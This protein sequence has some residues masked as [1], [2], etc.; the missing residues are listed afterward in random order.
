MGEQEEA[1]G[2]GRAGPWE[3][4]S[5]EAHAEEQTAHLVIAVLQGE[6]HRRQNK[7]LFNLHLG[8]CKK[9]RRVSE[10]GAAENSAPGAQHPSPCPFPAGWATRMAS[11]SSSSSSSSPPLQPG[12]GSSAP[13]S[14][15]CS[16]GTGQW[17]GGR[18]QLR[19]PLPPQ[20]SRA[21]LMICLMMSS[22]PTRVLSLLLSSF[23]RRKA[24]TRSGKEQAA[25]HSGCHRR[26]APRGGTA[27]GFGVQH[28]TP[29]SALPCTPMCHGGCMPA[30]PSPVLFRKHQ[31]C[32]P[33]WL[34]SW[35]SGCATP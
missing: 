18:A 21:L 25:G 17:A 28:H 5:P 2:D 35:G 10:D 9:K 24:S 4:L 12:T 14:S 20:H 1:A 33:S 26:A 6:F 27:G 3:H 13:C 32:C 16:Q 23:G 15:V 29:R 30:A 11:S 7:G 34:G 8:G 19:T 22:V 31:G